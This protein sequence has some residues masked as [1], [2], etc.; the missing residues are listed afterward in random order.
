MCE[1]RPPRRYEPSSGKGEVRAA[2]RGRV[3]QAALQQTR[4]HPVNVR[5]LQ[6]RPPDLEGSARAR[7]GAPSRRV[8][9]SGVVTIQAQA[10]YSRTATLSSARRVS[11]A[12]RKTTALFVDT[13]VPVR[14][15]SGD[16]PAQVP[17]AV[18]LPDKPL[19]T[20]LET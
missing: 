13:N 18:V 20:R 9:R 10:R 3:D 11:S 17:W 1:I 19:G 4:D 14:H 7:S 6:Q 15:L 2:A 5:C 16:P 12:A 8:E